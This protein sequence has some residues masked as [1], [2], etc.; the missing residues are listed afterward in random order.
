M[1]AVEYFDIDSGLS[2]AAGE[3]AE[4]TGLG[5]IQFLD[6]DLSLVQYLDAACFQGA[7]SSGTIFEEEVGYALCIDD[8]CATTFDA[9]PGSAESVSHGG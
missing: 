3:L 8:P 1:I 5:L 6:K 9:Y 2:H 4:L 7:S